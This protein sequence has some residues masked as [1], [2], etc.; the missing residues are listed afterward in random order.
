MAPLVR[1]LPSTQWNCDYTD[2]G[3]IERLIKFSVSK[4]ICPFGYKTVLNSVIEVQRMYLPCYV[5]EYISATGPN[6][7]YIPALLF[8][9]T[10][11]PYIFNHA[12]LYPSISR[13][14]NSPRFIGDP[15]ATRYPVDILT[16]TLLS[17]KGFIH[18]NVVAT[19]FHEVV[20]D[21]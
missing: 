10:G 9:W 4:E 16:R 11:K 13:I 5:D 7:L 19:Y 3:R 21:S 18:E 15:R 20:I 14:Y 17:L 8:D 2:I 12:S 1:F 6:F